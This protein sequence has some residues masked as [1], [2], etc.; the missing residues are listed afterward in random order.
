MSN[1]RQIAEERFARGEISEEEFNSIIA[2]I[3]GNEDSPRHSLRE[4]R[5]SFGSEYDE[6]IPL[7]EDRRIGGDSHAE[8]VRARGDWY[9]SY[10]DERRRGYSE[11]R[12]ALGNPGRMAGFWYRVLAALIDTV[13]SYILT[14]I[15]VFP[16]AFLIGMSMAGSATQQEL[17]AVGN[18]F[19]GILGIVIGWLWFT[20][21]ESS[22]WRA[23]VGKKIVGLKVT[24]EHGAQIGFGKAN[25][26][27]W[28]KILSALILMIGF[29]MV[30][31]T[32]N[33][34]GLHDK[35]AKTY[36]LKN[37]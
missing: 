34:Q 14:I 33:K 12:S 16:L 25:A 5:Y 15:V 2:R 18:I 36:V 31:F 28:S 13:L 7:R 26:R 9:D 4:D 37:R 19:G 21:P 32:E 27:Y 6:R 30:A 23:S 10:E 24:D 17:E 3:S 35:I 29:I 20:L 22:S 1:P 11:G 8:P